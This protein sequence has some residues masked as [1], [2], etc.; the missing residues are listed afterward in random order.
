MGVG[1]PSDCT[2]RRMSRS[3]AVCVHRSK[4][5]ANRCGSAC[6]CARSQQHTGPRGKLAG[7]EDPSCNDNVMH[8][9]DLADLTCFPCSD[10]SSFNCRCISGICSRHARSSPS[11]SAPAPPS[12]F[13]TRAVPWTPGAGAA[14]EAAEGGSID[15]R[16]VCKWI[17][18]KDQ[19]SYS[20]FGCHTHV[21]VSADS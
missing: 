21:K 8:S 19:P 1:T 16:R 12:V 4:S 20:D 14:S 3:V 15:F 17:F 10:R 2:A 7:G 13:P 11:C 18:L 6:N 5:Q 9:Q